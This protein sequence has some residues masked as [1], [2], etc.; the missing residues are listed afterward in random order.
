MAQSSD[1]VAAESLRLQ[2]DRPIA[3][4]MWRIFATDELEPW[5]PGE[6]DEHGNQW[7]GRIVTWHDFRWQPVGRAPFL[8]NLEPVKPL[9]PEACVNL[10]ETDIVYA[11]LIRGVDQGPPNPPTYGLGFWDRLPPYIRAARQSSAL[12]QPWC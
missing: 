6:P 10:C 3:L 11:P 8:P 12:G 9:T 7:A 5:D 4:P 1:L 2:W